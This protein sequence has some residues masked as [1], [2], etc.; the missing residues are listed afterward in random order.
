MTSI[1]DVILLRN[2]FVVLLGC[3]SAQKCRKYIP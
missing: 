3:S 1:S 2:L